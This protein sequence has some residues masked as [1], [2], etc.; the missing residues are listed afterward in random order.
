MVTKSG[1]L[2]TLGLSAGLLSAAAGNVS[3]QEPQDITSQPTTTQL[4]GNP[5]VFVQGDVSLSDID[6]KGGVYFNITPIFS[7][8][9]YGSYNLTPFG[10]INKNR[11]VID[12]RE[13]E[14]IGPGTYKQVNV[15]TTTEREMEYGY[16][17]GLLFSM[18]AGNG[19]RVYAGGGVSQK[20]ERINEHGI[21][22]ITFTR[23][24]EVLESATLENE[25]PQRTR[26]SVVPTG[27]LALTR[28]F[29]RHAE[30]GGFGSIRDGK[31]RG[32]ITLRLS[33]H[34]VDF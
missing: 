28:E 22:E 33:G 31:V 34:G 25:I 19:F 6:L 8:M 26:N 5:G 9:A 15:R 3:A 29:G 17:A 14:L 24:D 27:Y 23:N 11:T 21:K 16:G 1:L 4:R 13:Q 18:L 32:G 20:V 2:K 7:A 30:I 12:N 10:D